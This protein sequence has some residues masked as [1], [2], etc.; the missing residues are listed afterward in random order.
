MIVR[1]HDVQAAREAAEG[2]MQVVFF[3]TKGR[4]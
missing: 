1:M 2:Q 3:Q 4:G